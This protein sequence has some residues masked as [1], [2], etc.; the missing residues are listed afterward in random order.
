MATK[1]GRRS[2]AL[3]AGL[4]AVSVGLRLV[5]CTPE[6][7][8]PPSALESDIL[9]AL[10]EQVIQRAGDDPGGVESFLGLFVELSAEAAETGFA[11][12]VAPRGG[13]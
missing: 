9:L 13:Q 5:G 2:W 12:L 8:T 10:A 11:S 7:T 6:P 4:G 3:V 1:A